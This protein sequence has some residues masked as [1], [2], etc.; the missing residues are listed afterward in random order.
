MRE[1][2]MKRK[3]MYDEL[4]RN[5]GDPMPKAGVMF[6]RVGNRINCRFNRKWSAI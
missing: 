4:K 6:V 5:E 2:G 3:H 1:P